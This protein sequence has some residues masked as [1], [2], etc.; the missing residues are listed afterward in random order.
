[1]CALTQRGPWA[2]GLDSLPLSSAL[3]MGPARFASGSVLW[4]CGATDAHSHRPRCDGETFMVVAFAWRSPAGP[5]GC[6][7]LFKSRWR[8]WSMPSRTLASTLVLIL[9]LVLNSI[10]AGGAYPNEAAMR[11]PC[12]GILR[13][14]HRQRS[15][16]LCSQKRLP[17]GS[18]VALAGR[19]RGARLG[20]H[21]FREPALACRAFQ[22]LRNSQSAGLHNRAADSKT[23]SGQ[24]QHSAGS[25]E[26]FGA[27]SHDGWASVGT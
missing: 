16:L 9:S 21:R 10:I 20:G 1:M 15:L 6:P 19:P 27:M 24:V 5:F 17:P 18:P 13:V 2:C 25:I 8:L 23:R 7:G 12:P 14:G 4:R 3:S 26:L 22:L 11:I